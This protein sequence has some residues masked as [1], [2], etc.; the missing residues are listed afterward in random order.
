MVITTKGGVWLWQ[1]GDGGWEEYEDEVSAKI[2]DA[3]IKK[4]GGK[5][6]AVSVSKDK[7]VSLSD[8]KQF[9]FAGT[10]KKGIPVKREEKTVKVTWQWENGDHWEDYA[11]SVAQTI[12]TA[13]LDKEEKVT[14]DSERFV[15]FK[16]MRQVR[17]DNEKRYRNI[18]REVVTEVSDSSKDTEEEEEEEKDEEVEVEETVVKWYW[19]KSSDDDDEDEWVEF[20]E[21]MIEQ[22]E[23]GY[24]K[25]LEGDGSKTLP[26]DKERHINF[27]KM[28]QVRN[29]DPERYRKVKR[30]ITKIT[31]K[32]QIEKPKKAKKAQTTPTKTTT[33]TT[34]S[35]PDKKDKSPTKTDSDT[36]KKDSTANKKDATP[37][38]KDATPNKDDA[39]PKKDDATPK[40]DDATPK[41]DSTPKKEISKLSTSP[42]TSSTTTTTTT[43]S[44]DAPKKMG[45]RSYSDM[46]E[47]EKK[48]LI[49]KIINDEN[50]AKKPKVSSGL[51]LP[52]EEEILQGTTVMKY[53]LKPNR[54]FDSSVADLH[55]RTAESQFH[56]LMETNTQSKVALVEYI[57][58]PDLHA[59]FE[60]KRK[61]FEKLG[62]GKPLLAFHG[63]A[64]KNINLICKTNF[65]VPG[66]GVAHATDSGWY[67][68][69]IY[70]SEYPDYSMGYIKD[71]TRLLLSKVLL[72]N[73]F[74]CKG[75]ITGQPLM[76]GYDSHISPCGKELV[77]FSPDQ[78]LPI[79][80]VH[81][82]LKTGA[83]GFNVITT[84]IANYAYAKSNVFKGLTFAIHG[85][86]T[87]LATIEL[88]IK[89]NGGTVTTVVK[90][91]NY[92]ITTA[93]EYA[94]KSYPIT[95]AQTSGGTFIVSE[96]F[97]TECIKSG[98]IK[99]AS[100]FGFEKKEEKDGKSDAEIKAVPLTAGTDDDEEEEDEKPLPM[101]KFGENCYRKNAEHFKS[102]AHPW[103]I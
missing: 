43:T 34:T 22:I 29:D 35:T 96:D 10:D 81:Y 9:N 15:S 50:S 89:N 52:G 11:D 39:T 46:S 19:D 37:N 30:G 75:L 94:A 56:R 41:K 26:I 62:Y 103:L 90:Y 79:Y 47:E 48:E 17:L 25:Y 13:F 38:K 84:T 32:K 64:E 95:T 23:E 12:E 88:A 54:Y 5:S 70:F 33:T 60:A 67:G 77:I 57:V 4:G 72:G 100:K 3:H 87:P 53:C 16:K 78:I 61:E 93:S 27:R 99:K 21:K 14:L 6:N 102:F 2:E 83:Y 69:G 55:F 51:L 91:V 59:K 71:C 76:K 58:N 18:R 44:D 68:K 80:I 97:L 66:K 36:P 28:R 85:T 74:Q 101:C 98:K 7:F 20:N 24:Q 31:V 40:K 49:L 86:T 73:P 82:S 1:K 63:T 92:L 42:S 65:C 45:K 8:M